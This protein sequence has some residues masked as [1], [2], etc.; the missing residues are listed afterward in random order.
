MPFLCDFGR[1]RF[2]SKGAGVQVPNFEHFLHPIYYF[3]AVC[4]VAVS[5]ISDPESR[6]NPEWMKE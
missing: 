2:S 1:V 3:S 6:I 5:D 4:P